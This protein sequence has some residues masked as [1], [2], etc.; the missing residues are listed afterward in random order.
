VS[1]GGVGEG[2]DVGQ[3]LLLV[4][5]LVEAEFQLVVDGFALGDFVFDCRSCS[6]MLSMVRPKSGMG[7]ALDQLSSS[8]EVAGRLALPAARAPRPRERAG[9]V[10][11]R[12]SPTLFPSARSSVA[13]KSW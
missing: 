9:G 4:V 10:Q 5:A 3:E 11:A 1:T 13:T 2:G 7:V 6:V 8:V 12:R